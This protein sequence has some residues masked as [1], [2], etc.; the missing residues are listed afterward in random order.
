VEAA[1]L[2]DGLHTRRTQKERQP[3]ILISAPYLARLLSKV[4][5]LPERRR[6]VFNR[7]SARRRGRMADTDGATHILVGDVRNLCGER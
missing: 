7:C 4:R 1:A 2:S 3:Y 6:R 5:S